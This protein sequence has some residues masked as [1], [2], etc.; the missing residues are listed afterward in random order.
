MRNATG[1]VQHAVILGGGSDIAQAVVARLAEGGLARAVLAAR[2]PIEVVSAWNRNHGGN[3]PDLAVHGV[4]YDTVERGSAA[5]V[6]EDAASTADID[7]VIIAAG[8]LGD[9]SHNH[10]AS[11]AV[12][13]LE[14]NLIG[15]AEALIDSIDRLTGQGH[16][17]VVVL[18]SVAGQRARGPLAAY[19]GSKAGLDALA[20]GVQDRLAG[21]S[22]FITI[23]RP[24]F[25]ATKMTAG[26]DPAPFA[27]TPEAVA[28]DIVRA[29]VERRA[30]VWSPAKLRVVFAVLRLLPGP[31]WRRISG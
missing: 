20:L 4:H 31:L 10:D 12:D 29:M 9:D 27:T 11:A 8:M 5:K 7:V 23:V 1:L 30:V 21:S 2:S 19:G 25:V 24:G 6:L 13:M 26:L 16:G 28:D 22:V 15:P 14:T 3:H 18:S 17:H